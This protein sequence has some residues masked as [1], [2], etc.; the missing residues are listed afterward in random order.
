MIAKKVLL[1]FYEDVDF[2]LRFPLIQIFTYSYTKYVRLSCPA[3][4]EADPF[5]TIFLLFPGQALLALHRPKYKEDFELPIGMDI[6][7]G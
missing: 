1:P 5:Q 6:F 2:I 3:K 7:N 4:F